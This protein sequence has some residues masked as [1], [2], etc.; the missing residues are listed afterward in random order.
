[1]SDGMSEFM[2]GRMSKILLGRM[3][4][5]MSDRLPFW[6]TEW[7]NIIYVRSAAFLGD[8]LMPNYLQE[9]WLLQYQHV[10]IEKSEAA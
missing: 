7:K 5:L 3:S 10:V 9:C 2:S 4:D 8:H 6:L 1:M